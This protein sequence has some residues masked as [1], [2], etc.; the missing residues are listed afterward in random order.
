MGEGNPSIL[1]ELERTLA[2]LAFEEPQKSPFA[3]LLQTS[4]RQKVTKLIEIRIIII[5]IYIYILNGLFKKLYSYYPNTYNHITI[6]SNPEVK[7][8]RFNRKN[9]SL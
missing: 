5:A 7:I 6:K 2:L 1:T 9:F 4:H 8:P 3:D